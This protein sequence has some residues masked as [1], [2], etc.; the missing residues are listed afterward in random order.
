MDKKFKIISLSV[1]LVLLMVMAYSYS[2][3]PFYPPDY[4]SGPVIN[5]GD[6]V[7]VIAP[8]PDDEVICNGGVVHYA[9]ENNIAVR[10]VVVTDGDDGKTS[11]L[12]RYNESIN[13]T[14][15]LGLSEE[16]LIFLGYRDGSLRNLLNDNWNYSNP[17]T[18]SDGST[19]TNYPYAFQKNATYCGANLEEN[20]ETIINDFNPTVVVYPSGDDEQFDHQALSGLTEYTLTRSQYNGSKY[21][22]LLHLPPKWPNPRSYYSEYYLVPPSKLVGLEKGPNWFIFNLSSYTERLKEESFLAYKTQIVSSSYLWSF[23]RKNELFAQYPTL[24]INA[25][26]NGTSVS[27]NSSD[28]ST[29]TTLFND[30]EGDGKYEGKYK[31]T[32]IMAVGMD[33]SNDGSYMSL[34]TVSTPSPEG[35]YTIHMNIFNPSGTEMVKITTQNGTTHLERNINGNSTTEIVPVIVKNNTIIIKLPSE[36]FSNSQNFILSADS[37]QNSEI[38]DQT[39]WRVIKII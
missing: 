11:P 23:L 12:T 33:I 32:D 5:Q 26:S 31:S 6:R 10:V 9:V 38:I 39:P 37:S 30:A 28:S 27:Y 3:L 20:L 35:I 7:L 22:Y 24:T 2:Q 4:P 34:K 25:K 19:H 16:N 29:P 1:V 8:H 21:S 13:G 36:L 14:K 15:V 18:A 17:F